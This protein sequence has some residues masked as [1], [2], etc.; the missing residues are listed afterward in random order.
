MMFELLPRTVRIFTLP[1]EILPQPRSCSSRGNKASAA[2][3]ESDSTG[4]RP[5]LVTHP[6]LVI[7]FDLAT[8]AASGAV[9]Q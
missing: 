8:T 5:W 2:A 4:V 7:G 1:G 3:K 9:G 6:C